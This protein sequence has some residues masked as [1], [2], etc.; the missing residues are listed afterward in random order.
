MTPRPPHAVDVL[1]HRIDPDLP[2]PSY[3]HPGDAGLDLVTRVAAVVAPG[4][5]VL[6]PTGVAI[7]LPEG[8]AAFVHPRSGLAVRYGVSLVNAPGTI[9]AGYRG[10]IAVSVVNL[11][12]REPVTFDRGDRVAQ[13]VVQR[14]EHA[15]LHEVESLPGSDRGAGG[16]GSSGR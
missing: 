14:V 8:Y 2:L 16:F 11:D 10:E 5:R 13:L 4:E 7:A 3:A 12:P 1:V 15:V 6:L 9:D